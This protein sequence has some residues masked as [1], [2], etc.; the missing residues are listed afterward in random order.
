MVHSVE[1][2]TLG[3]SPGHDLRDLGLSPAS[4][5][6]LTAMSAA[7]YFSL[8]LFLPLLKFFYLSLK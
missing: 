4:D 7:D 2:P 1:G 5:S 8:P 6:V 3:F